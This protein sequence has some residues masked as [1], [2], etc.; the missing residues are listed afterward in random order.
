MHDDRREFERH[1]VR[2]EGKVMFAAGKCSF[3]CVIVDLSVAGARLRL[4][5][6]VRLPSKIYLWQTKSGAV[7][8]CE[9]R[10][11]EQTEVGLRFID[12]CGRQLRKVLLKATQSEPKGRISR[13]LGM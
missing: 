5:Q 4:T 6:N 2:I 8:E 3:D 9:V 12:S 13:W 10:W 7:L 1:P 11:Q